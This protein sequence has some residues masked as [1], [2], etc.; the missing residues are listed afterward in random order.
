MFSMDSMLADAQ[1]G[2]ALPDSPPL[3]PV[4]DWGD[5]P[6]LPGGDG[7]PGQPRKRPITSGPSA[8]CGRPA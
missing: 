7:A 8:S 4:D 1:S 2:I 5:L 6:P 3:V